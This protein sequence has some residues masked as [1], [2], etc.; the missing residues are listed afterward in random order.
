VDECGGCLGIGA[1]K[2]WCEIHVG[3]SAAFYGRLSEAAEALG[4][5]IG[6]N[7]PGAANH[8]YAAAGMLKERAL[9]YKKL[10]QDETPPPPAGDS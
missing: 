7:D 10:W 3:R 4:D 1:H 6:G 5:R 9:A 8:C 2:R